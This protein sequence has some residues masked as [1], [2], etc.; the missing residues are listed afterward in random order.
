MQLASY[1]IIKNIKDK[2]L[3][4]SLVSHGL[5]ERS[6]ASETFNMLSARPELMNST[7]PRMTMYTAEINEY[8]YSD[9]SF[10]MRSQNDAAFAASG[11]IRKLQDSSIGPTVTKGRFYPLTLTNNQNAPTKTVKV[12]KNTSRDWNIQYFH[13]DPQ[14]VT[15]ELTSEVPYEVRS[16]LLKAHADIMMQNIA[17]YTAVQWAQGTTSA[18]TTVNHTSGNN[19]YQFTSGTATR[20]NLVPGNTAGTVKKVTKQDMLNVKKAL[21]RQQVVG[22]GGNM[23]FLPTPEMYDDL[24][25]IPEFVDYEKTGRESKL[26]MGE[27][28]TILGITILN[29]RHREDW[30]G[31]VL[32]SYTASS[33][34]NTD[35]TKVDDTGSAAANQVTAGMAWVDNYVL[36]AEGSTIVFPWLNSPIYLGDVYAIESR[37]GA[38]R[39]RADNKGVVMLVENPF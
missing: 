15:R 32:Y 10:M 38:I 31:N 37:F 27:V 13:T 12:R 25:N 22:R 6:K 29:P 9:Q 21:H 14:S 4:K 33:G 35:L 3:K 11:D 19:F 36:R 20:T 39:K 34:G 2:D 23:Y 26:I 1:N 28:G 5:D 7:E 16:E 30:E 17:N 8:L 18:A 24:L